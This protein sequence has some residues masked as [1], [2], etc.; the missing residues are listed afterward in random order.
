[1][2]DDITNIKVISKKN[3]GFP[4]YLNFDKLRTESIDYLGELSGKIWTDHNAHDPGITILEVLC[5]ALLDL[6]YR[7]NIP[8]EDIIARNPND[9]TKDDHFFTAAEILSCNPLTIIDYRKLLIEIPGVKNAWLEVA[10]DQKDICKR[11][12]NIGRENTSQNKENCIEYLNGIYHV[13]IETEKNI[14]EEFATEVERKK[15]IDDLILTI[16]KTLV[17]HR[18]LC[19]D[20]ADITLLCK[21]KTGICADIELEAGA[22]AEKIYV[23]IIKK[24]RK[25]FSPSPHF[26]T[27]QQLLDNNKPIEDIF[28]G[29]PYNIVASNGFIDTAELE[30]LKLKKEIHLSDVYNAIFEIPDVKKIKKIA[31]RVEENGSMVQKKDWKI[32]LPVNNISDF[33]STESFITFSINEVPVLFDAKKYDALFELNFTHNGKLLYKNPSP[34]LD[35]E[36]PKGIYRAD[37]DEYFSIQNDFPQVYGI[38]EGGLAKDVDIKRK[39][40]AL[41]LKGYL[42]FFDQLLC[43]YLAQLKNIRSLFSV[44]ENNIENKKQTYFLNKLTTVPDLE[45]LLRFAE[46]D[47]ADNSL[48]TKGSKLIYPVAKDKLLELVTKNGSQNADPHTLDAFTFSSLTEQEITLNILKN[49]FYNGNIDVKYINEG[50][51]SI[52]YYITASTNEFVLVSNKFFSSE[53]AAKQHADSINYIATFDENYRTFITAENHVSF[54]I[55]LNMATY[56]EYLQGIIEDKN[57]YAIRRNYFLNH[58]LA[59]FAERFTD[60]AM[61]SFGNLSAEET[62]L[63]DIKN[64]ELFLSNY[65]Y[66]SSNRGMAYDYNKNNWLNNNI[67][68]FENEVKYLSGI[69]NKKLHSLCNFVVEAYEEEFIIDL[70]TGEEKLFEI[71]EKFS[72]REDAHAAI[73]NLLTAL[74]DTKNYSRHYDNDTQRYSLQVKYGEKNYAVYPQ[75]FNNSLAA[76][77]V[78]DNLY[79]TYRNKPAG[80]D[81][82]ISKYRHRILLNDSIGNV[83]ARSIEFFNSMEE[84]N[85]AIK[86]LISNI[87]DKK[88]WVLENE[89]ENVLG[90]LL[91]NKNNT[92]T[93]RFL[94]T[95]AFKIDVNSSIIGKPDKFTYE[96]LDKENTFKLCP[97]V[98]FD[99]AKDAE[100]HFKKMLALATDKNNF[101]ITRDNKNGNYGIQIKDKGIAN[102][103]C[104]QGFETQEAAEA[105]LQKIND[106]INQQE[107]TLAIETIADKWKYNYNLG[108]RENNRYSF[109]STNDYASAEAALKAATDFSASTSL[110]NKKVEK[111]N[112]ILSAPNKGKLTNAVSLLTAETGPTKN[113]EKEIEKIL[114]EKREVEYFIAKNK[115]SSFNAA[116]KV[117]ETN[118][119]GHYVY[120]LVD[121][122]NVIAHHTTAYENKEIAEQEKRKVYAQLQK[123]LK[124]TEICLGGDIVHKIIKTK[125]SSPVYRYQIKDKNNC[126]TAGKN[127]GSK[128]ILFESKEEFSTSELAQ[129]AFEKNYIDVLGLA[130]DVNN[131]GKFIQLNE[132]T[133]TNKNNDTIVFI[134]A[135]TS[136]E[137][138]KVYKTNVVQWMLETANNYPIRRVEYGSLKF[139]EL[140][141]GENSGT[142]KDNCACTTEAIMYKYYFSIYGKEKMPELWLSNKY[143]ETAQEARKDFTFFIM[144]ISFY[145]NLFTDCDACTK[146]ETGKYK[147]YIREVLAESVKRYEQKDIQLIWG[148]DGI[149]KFICAVQQENSFSNYQK[150]EDCCYSFYVNCGEDFIVH[151]CKYDTSQQRS[152]VL[153]Q[154]QERFAETIQNKSYSTEIQSEKLLLLDADGK[155]FAYQLNIA[156]QNTVDVVTLINI[157]ENIYNTENQ[158][159]EKESELFLADKSGQ[160]ILQSFEKGY[161]IIEWRKELNAFGC[162]FPIVKKKDKKTNSEKY[163]IEIKLPGFG[164]CEEIENDL[165]PCNCSDK[166]T[167][168]ELVCD[169]AWKS[170]CCYTLKELGNLWQTYLQLQKFLLSKQSYIAVFDCECNSFGIAFQFNNSLRSANNMGIKTGEKIA[171]NP[172]CYTLPN[173]VCDAAERTKKLVN[174]EGLHLVEHIL[175][176]PQNEGDCKCRNNDTNCGER[177]CGYKWEFPDTD[178]C[179]IQKASCF[180]PGSDPFSFI[181]TVA[182]PAWPKRFRTAAGRMVMENIMYRTAPAHVLLRILWLTPYDFCRFETNYKKWHLMLAGKST[183]IGNF[184]TCEMLDFVFKQQ[185]TCLDD[186]ID[187][188]PCKDDEPPQTSC[189]TNDF[190]P[191]GVNNFVNEI[192]DLHCF[193][194]INCSD[195]RVIEDHE[196]RF[197][198]SIGVKNDPVLIQENNTPVKKEST[199]LKPVEIKRIEKIAKENPLAEVAI[200]PLPSF[201]NSR[202][203][204]YK[205]A[206]EVV[207]NAVQNNMIAVKAERFLKT[208]SP[209]KI[210]IDAIVTEIIQNKKPTDNNGLTINKNRKYILL[211]NIVCY[212]LDKAFFTGT[213]L[214]QVKLLTAIFSKIESAGFDMNTIYEHWNSKQVK[215]YLPEINVTEIK[216]TITEVG[217]K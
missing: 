168:T 32:L 99:T 102:A 41:Q 28:S 204:G 80:E 29:R 152:K 135:E 30:I 165:V 104:Y 1:M 86:K 17:A 106:F 83:K 58:L 212:S 186:C 3:A 105:M 169:I 92:D 43:N 48:G 98:E 19:E 12:N 139:N 31:L 51:K 53:A 142:I 158:V 37:L 167:E 201:V 11:R 122:D 24:L 66:I 22:D 161:T 136:N 35:T 115:K 33:L 89:K 195:N 183:C 194:T 84:A 40:K 100:N 61:L 157:V 154:L 95:A 217:R 211:E 127:I 177:N 197:E 56:E 71:K 185:F 90:D 59:R 64:K 7:T 198:K 114:H 14:E 163:C 108:Y 94:N 91:Y 173:M 205:N 79:K 13:F 128:I 74:A 214:E 44:S 26:Y 116:V 124:Y 97:A 133:G 209:T 131:Y 25:F 15:Y 210:Q 199:V 87:N 110:L 134:P 88:K 10:T 75:Q 117:D 34:Y 5:Y 78:A 23:A 196:N 20:F 143:Y 138:E 202:M 188:Q 192:N 208:T 191:K 67:S 27:L 39:A 206:V 4:A 155:P 36:I 81:I 77:S 193:Q 164:N 65:D 216:K 156:T 137:I 93:T 62:A 203:A 18:D 16:K 126:Y 63:A 207:K 178:P 52:Y 174:A 96:A 149:E 200:I 73:R 151:P 187:C 160:V 8:V 148:K 175:L 57:M 125:N 60:F 145:G 141:C 153:Y 45:K 49:D 146:Q 6:G 47:S 189:F 72:S 76:D 68:G 118:G 215:K 171:Y 190:V 9:T 112:V 180:Y 85:A 42:L 54:N 140:F 123:S 38:S 111:Q 170:S 162:Y 129:E 213:G 103:M 182:L 50:T 144:L 159:T 120:R 184:D 107:Y 132:P 2:V 101:E 176:R 46:N 119:L 69:E 113:T 109:V 166:P 172:Q 121:K 21:Q 130:T 82:F 147:I 55:E 179:N 150:K 181:A 70:K